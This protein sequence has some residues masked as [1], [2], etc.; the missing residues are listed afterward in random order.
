LQVL[1]RRLISDRYA[2]HVAQRWICNKTLRTADRKPGGGGEFLFVPKITLSTLTK[3]MKANSIVSARYKYLDR[4]HRVASCTLL[5]IYL[6]PTTLSCATHGLSLDPKKPYKGKSY[7]HR[8][9]CVESCRACSM[10][11]EA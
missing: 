5:L 9:G 2:G 3:G 8:L 10:Y 11:N 7:L 6:Q 1:C 4:T